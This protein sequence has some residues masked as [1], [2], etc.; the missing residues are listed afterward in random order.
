MRTVKYSSWKSA[1]NANKAS[2]IVFTSRL[3]DTVLSCSLFCT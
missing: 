1:Q 3:L 2:K